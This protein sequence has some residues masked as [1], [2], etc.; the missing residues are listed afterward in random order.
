MEKINLTELKDQQSGTVTKITGGSGL[1][2]RLESL[3]IRTG[4]KI[5]K[6]SRGFMKGPVIVKACNTLVSLG[7]G[8]A[9]KIFVKLEE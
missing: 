4:N 2:R 5:T 1:Q 3:G 8:M 6:I 7:Y 9:S